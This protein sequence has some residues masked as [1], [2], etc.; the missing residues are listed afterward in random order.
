MTARHQELL[1]EREDHSAEIAKPIDSEEA[2]K[3]EDGDED[4]DEDRDEEEDYVEV[5]K[6]KTGRK[7]EFLNRELLNLESSEPNRDKYSTKVS[8]FKSHMSQ[9][10]DEAKKKELESTFNNLIIPGRR[11]EQL[12]AD[13]SPLKALLSEFQV[14]IDS[15][16]LKDKDL[17]TTEENSTLEITR[18]K[19]EEVEEEMQ[20]ILEKEELV[21]AAWI[22]RQFGKA[23]SPG[24]IN[25][26]GGIYERKY[27]AWSI[28]EEPEIKIPLT[29]NESYCE[30]F[31]FHFNIISIDI[32]SYMYCQLGLNSSAP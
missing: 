16:E 8:R 19:Y 26:F 5:E 28:T 4:G 18:Q 14:I 22:T 27:S 11:Q 29:K 9:E 7:L 1:K 30:Y 31:A 21:I 3:D 32:Y 25:E 15:L 23:R 6:F 12:K 2:D 13:I 10:N 20:S 24:I 17:R